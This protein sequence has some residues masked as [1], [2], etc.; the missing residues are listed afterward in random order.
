MAHRVDA[1][2]STVRANSAEGRILPALREWDS[3]RGREWVWVR[4]CRRRQL[5]ANLQDA[6]GRRL[7]VR[8]SAMSKGQKKGR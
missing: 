4:D 7:A 2:S 8:D 3:R 5:R 1:R 6:Q